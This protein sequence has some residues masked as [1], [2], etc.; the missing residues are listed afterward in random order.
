[1][2][3]PAW[4]A[5]GA[6]VHGTGAV[7]PT[8]PAG[9]A[10]QHIEWL[11]VESQA[12]THSL[13][14]PNGF[15]AAAAQIDVPSGTAAIAT[16]G[17]LWWRRYTGQADPVVAAATNHILAQRFAFSACIESGN[18]WDFVQPSSEGVE[19][20]SGSATGN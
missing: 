17:S 2:A 15:A 13:S 3:F 8:A 19:D 16:R 14:T 10:A 1:M 7:T 6:L 5:N 20:T 12:G 9:L 11:L 18:P 4:V